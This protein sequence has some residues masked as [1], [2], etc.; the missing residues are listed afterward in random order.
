MSHQDQLCQP[1]TVSNARTLRRAVESIGQHADF[2]EIKLRKDC[3][4]KP[5]TLAAAGLFWALSDE[6]TLTGRHDDARKITQKAFRLQH[7]LAGSYQ[8]FTKILR[9]WSTAIVAAWVL[10][11]REEM[12]V[13]FNEH[14]VAGYILLGVDGSRIELPRTR[15]NQEHY[16]ALSAL[17]KRRR[18]RRTRRTKSQ[19]KKAESPQSWITTMW[20]VGT[21]L[22]WDWRD[23]RSDSSER[24]HLLE[25]I[26]D[27]PKDAMV[28][29][30]AGFIGYEYWKALIDSEHPFVIRVGSNV[31]LLKNLGYVRERDGIV[32]LWPD[33][34]AKRGEPPIVLRLVVIEGPRHPVYLV[35][36]VLD[37]KRL[38]D[39][40]IA[41]IYRCRWGVEVFYRSFKQTFRRRKLLARRAEH[42]RLELHWSLLALWTTCLYAKQ[43]QDVASDRV[44]V[45][46]VLHGFRHCMREYRSLPEHDDDLP[47][48]LSAAVM[49]NNER[50]NKSSRDYPRKKRESPPGK[51]TIQLATEQQIK[52]ATEIK[53]QTRK[54]G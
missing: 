47:T 25:M 8:A 2:Q 32:S 30:D 53:S 34:M 46:K 24:S 3:S 23:G 29:A 7:Q 40:Q 20:H 41:E 33:A 18:K 49:D 19:R 14:R 51:P 36:S 42:V 4:W 9:R 22:P 44:S 12:A 11:I 48:L 43:W 37:R 1:G 15:S 45:A 5:M 35:T 26:D 6:E 16:C 38:T 13:Y 28:T 50:R 54:K 21:D 31:K 52:R 10:A 39:A 27:L 17:G